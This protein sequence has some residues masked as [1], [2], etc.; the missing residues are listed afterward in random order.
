MRVKIHFREEKIGKMSLKFPTLSPT[1]NAHMIFNV[2][3]L[4][5][6][7]EHFL[8]GI[9]GKCL[10]FPNITNTE[11]YNQDQPVKIGMS[12]VVNKNVLFF[13]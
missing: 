13:I 9:E 4:A 6:L 2:H 10:F 12:L 1:S 7:K 5:I 3:S 11:N 8:W